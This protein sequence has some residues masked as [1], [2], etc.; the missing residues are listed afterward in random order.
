MIIII[1]K[2]V[3][4]L[5]LINKTKSMNLTLKDNFKNLQIKYVILK[6]RACLLLFIYSFISF[7]F[8]DIYYFKLD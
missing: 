1:I 3:K 8:E 2:I 4:M 7:I 6:Q 5:C